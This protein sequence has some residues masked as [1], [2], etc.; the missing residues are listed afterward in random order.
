MSSGQDNFLQQLTATKSNPSDNNLNVN[1]DIL[2][3]HLADTLLD[4]WIREKNI[5]STRRK[6]V[7]M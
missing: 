4:M 1:V 5:V 6:V 3:D 7:K 2:L